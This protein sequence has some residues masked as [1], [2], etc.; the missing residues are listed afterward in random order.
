VSTSGIRVI[1]GV[2]SLSSVVLGRVV[3]GASESCLPWR[4]LT[5]DRGTRSTAV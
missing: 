3:R 2:P 1:R 4:R 5:V